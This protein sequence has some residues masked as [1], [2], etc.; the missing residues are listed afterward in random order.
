MNGTISN[1]GAGKPASMEELRKAMM[2]IYDYQKEHGLPTEIT[3]MKSDMM[4]DNEGILFVGKDV[5]RKLK[6][7]G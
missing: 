7:I 5:Y 4:P 3:I 6:D 1:K 2:V